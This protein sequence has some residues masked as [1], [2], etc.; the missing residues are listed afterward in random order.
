MSE[1]GESDMG[2]G[3]WDILG[4][5]SMGVD[6]GGEVQKGTE[7]KRREEMRTELMRIV[8]TPAHFGGEGFL[9]GG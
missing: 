4:G 2:Y 8:H 6:F 1:Q 7:E 3:I 5:V 9:E